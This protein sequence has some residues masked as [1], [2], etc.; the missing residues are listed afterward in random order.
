MGVESRLECGQT[1]LATAGSEDGEAVGQGVWAA[2]G[3][4]DTPATSATWI[5]PVTQTRPA[6]DLLQRG[7]QPGHA[8][9]L[10]V[11][12]WAEHPAVPTWT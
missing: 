8:L 5:L 2:S 7:A 12:T 11:S 4:M 1:Q 10:P 9:A 3:E 6:A